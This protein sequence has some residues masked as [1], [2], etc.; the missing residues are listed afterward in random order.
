MWTA[1]KATDI[2]VY[3]KRHVFDAELP[4]YHGTFAVDFV[5]SP[6]DDADSSLPPRTSYYQQKEFDTLGSSDD[7]PMLI[8]LHGLSGGS[9][10]IY[11]RAVLK[12]LIDA[13]WQACVV[14]SRGCANSK[15]TSSV[16]Y[17]ARA[18]WDCRQIVKWTKERWPN[19]KLF[20]IGFSLGAN[21]MT[22][23]STA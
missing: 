18:T 20:G 6:T 2:P 9:Y 17:N 21:I 22:N 4:E 11:L 8:V 19:R 3:Y 16:L 5:V 1:A 13:G 23:V 7:T 14:N 10:E 15:I 12:P